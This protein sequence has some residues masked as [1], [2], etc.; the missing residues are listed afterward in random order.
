VFSLRD[1]DAVAAGD[2]DDGERSVALDATHTINTVVGDATE[3]SFVLSRGDDDAIVVRDDNAVA[4]GDDW[5]SLLAASSLSMLTSSRTPSSITTSL[6]ASASSSARTIT[7]DELSNNSEDEG[8][9]IIGLLIL[10]V[11]SRTV[12]LFVLS[13]VGDRDGEIT[14]RD[15]RNSGVVVVGVDV[16][17]GVVVGGGIV[18]VIVVVNVI[19]VASVIGFVVNVVVVGF[20][21]G[22]A[23][24][25]C[26]SAAN[27]AAFASAACSARSRFSLFRFLFRFFDDGTL[28]LMCTLRCARIRVGD[29]GSW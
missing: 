11:L 5:S 4:V 29:D 26:V 21:F 13:F 1:D 28:V 6:T 20:G 2:V 18:V 17:V 24:G 22:A 10:L 15:E 19:I 9:F 16:V 27:A 14:A 7:V 25:R 12:V 23:K 3:S 8:D